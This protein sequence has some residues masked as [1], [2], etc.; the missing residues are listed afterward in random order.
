MCIDIAYLPRYNGN[1]QL[2]WDQSCIYDDVL[3]YGYTD[4]EVNQ[5]VTERILTTDQYIAYC[6]TH[7]DHIALSEPYRSRF[8]EG[9]RSVVDAAGGKLR[10]IDTHVLTTVKKP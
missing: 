2:F 3:N 8:Y 6:G 5:F 7:C 10:I 4:R 1:P 9:I